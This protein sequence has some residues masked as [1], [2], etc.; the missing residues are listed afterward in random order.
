MLENVWAYS[1]LWHG[2]NMIVL[3]RRFLSDFRRRHGVVIT[4]VEILRK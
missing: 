4:G 3:S 1:F 2:K